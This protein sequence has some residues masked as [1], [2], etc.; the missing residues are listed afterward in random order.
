MGAHVLDR[1]RFVGAHVEAETGWVV[2][3]FDVMSG[4]VTR[5]VGDTIRMCW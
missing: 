5:K 4:V 3:M 2:F 1:G